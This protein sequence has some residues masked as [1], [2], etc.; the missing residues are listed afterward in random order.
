MAEAPVSFALGR[1][2]ALA[3]AHGLYRMIHAE[4]SVEELRELIAVPPH[5]E[6]VL[7]AYAKAHVED[8]HW[9]EAR[10]K[11]KQA[12]AGEFERLLCAG[13]AAMDL[14]QVDERELDP[15]EQGSAAA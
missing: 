4:C 12:V 7:R 13:T 9:I 10:L 15:V 2:S 3:E 11:F 5:I 6:R 14:P 1:Q 8:A